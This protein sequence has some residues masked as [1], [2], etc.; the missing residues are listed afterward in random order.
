MIDNLL[1]GGDSLLAFL[2]HP[3]FRFVKADVTERR[4]VKDGLRGDN[5]AGRKWPK[6]EAVV[7]LAAIVGF[8][9]CQA[10]GRQV[11]WR[12]NVDATKLVFE[13]ACEL[14]REEIHLLLELQQ[15]RTGA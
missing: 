9:A 4:A 13:Q 5:A 6:P 11:A 12:Y 7:H 3:R 10:V 8:P 15:L 1:F 2:P 14:G